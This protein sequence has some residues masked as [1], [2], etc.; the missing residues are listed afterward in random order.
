MSYRTPLEARI[1]KKTTKAITE[2]RDDAALRRQDEAPG[3][4]QIQ[5]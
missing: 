1:A 4:I 3:L 5:R 2:L